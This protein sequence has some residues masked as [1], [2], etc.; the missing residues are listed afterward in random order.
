MGPGRGC[1]EAGQPLTPA[2]GCAA[3]ARPRRL[4][5]APDRTPPTPGWAVPP[6]GRAAPLRLLSAAAAGRLPRSS[7]A[8]SGTA[9]R[10]AHRQP[11]PDLLLPTWPPP[12]PALGS[13]RR[14]Q[15]EI[16]EA[17]RNGRGPRLLLL[18]TDYGLNSR[19]TR[20]RPFPAHFKLVLGSFRKHPKPL[21][22]RGAGHAPAPP[23]PAADGNRRPFPATPE[24]GR[25]PGH[26][27]GWY[28]V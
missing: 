3:R 10:P 14:Q 12:P 2:R 26:S 28:R 24:A 6:F 18:A 27:L 22:V 4:R 5:A 13:F 17:A 15:P 20:R 1:G 19:N 9:P 11:P 7:P 8:L 16:S 21:R 25:V 23:S